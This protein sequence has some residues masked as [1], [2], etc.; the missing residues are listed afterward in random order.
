MS[1]QRLGE[2]VSDG[3]HF[4]SMDAD[5]FVLEVAKGRDGATFRW[6]V[7][8]RMGEHEYGVGHGVA[9]TRGAARLHALQIAHKWADG[10]VASLP[11]LPAATPSPMRTTEGDA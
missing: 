1:E 9:S 8:V 7:L 10:V 5:P 11:P 2:W 4:E 6:T 3:S